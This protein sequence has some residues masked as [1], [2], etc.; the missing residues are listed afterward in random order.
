[1][2]EIAKCHMAKGNQ[3]IRLKGIKCFNLTE[4]LKYQK[5][6]SKTAR[7]HVQLQA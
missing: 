3:F 4:P 7:N 5:Q 2:T 6:Y 1:M